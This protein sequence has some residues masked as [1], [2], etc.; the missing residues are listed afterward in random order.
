MSEEERLGRRDVLRAVA[1]TGLLG[2]VGAG[3][4]SGAPSGRHI[5]GT[6]NQ[7]GQRKAKGMADS[8]HRELEFG[9]VGAAVAGRFPEQAREALQ[10]NPNVRY[11]EPDGQ[12]QAIAQSLP[13]GVDRTD[14]EL[15]AADGETGAGADVAVVDTGIDSDHPDLE[16]NLGAGEAFVTCSDCGEPWGDDNDHGTHCAGIVGA[17]DNS[18][19]VVGV[20]SEATLHAVKVLYSN[21][22]GSFSDIAAGV[23]HVADQGWDVASLSIGGKYSSALAD[24]VQYAHDQGVLLV[25]AAG[26]TGSCTDCVLFPATHPDV[27]AVSATAND[28]SLASFSSTGPEVDVAAP[29][30][31]IESTVRDGTAVYSGTSMACPHVSG[32]GA[33]L[34][35]QGLSN[36]EARSR[37]ENTAEDVGLGAN[38]QGNGLLD[39]EAAIGGAGDD[40]PTASVAAPADGA[41]V[42]GTTTVQVDAS[43]AEDSASDLAVEVAIDGGAWQAASWVGTDGVHEYDW[44]TTSVGDG[45]HAVE[46]RATDSGGNSTSS[47]V[48]VTVD[49][50]AELSVKSIE[51]A[52]IDEP[53]VTL[54]GELTNSGGAES[55]DCSFKYWEKGRKSSTVGW[56]GYP[57][58]TESGLFS[59]EAIGLS[60]DTTYVFAARGKASDGDWDRGTRLEFTTG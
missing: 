44:D 2:G 4:A 30:A 23:T 59:A 20:A 39:A 46:A 28:D 43:D 42:S 37:I 15:T 34:M 54:E 52:N 50:V 41:T 27:V 13:W 7:R 60:A 14:A 25:A 32:V 9:A 53:S 38:E 19:A 10:K 8:V 35:S 51:A 56:A 6:S 57:T 5:V 18:R 40:P 48:T 12:M 3:V 22:W 31:G 29:G 45:D 36:V 26:N 33:L 55:V 11:V 49:N 1:A 47:S 17:A 16:A 58:L 21:G 24:A